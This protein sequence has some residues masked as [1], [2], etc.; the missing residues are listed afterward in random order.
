MQAI[1]WCCGWVLG[2]VVLVAQAQNTWNPDLN[3]HLDAP[4]LPEVLQA[5][6]ALKLNIL[7]VLGSHGQL[8]DWVREGFNGGGMV[9]T[10][11]KPIL[12]GGPTV[13]TGTFC[14]PHDC[15]DTQWQFVYEPK[16]QALLLVRGDEV[17]SNK[18]GKVASEAFLE[19]AR[20]SHQLN[21]M[22]W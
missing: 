12:T 7:E 17:L 6:P 2:G 1:K 5:T 8:D 14:K 4:Y 18:E 22:W 10:P 19:I 9:T 21:Y 11:V 20:I 13:F 3:Q 16:K 15:G